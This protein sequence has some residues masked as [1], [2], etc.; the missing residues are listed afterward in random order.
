ML[1]TG[2]GKFGGWETDDFLETGE[3]EIAA[4][5]E[6]AERLG[7]PLQRKRALDFGCGV[8]RAT[9]AL[10]PHFG[11]VL[12]V[13]ISETMIA[14][15]REL[16]ADRAGCTFLL[17]DTPDL[18]RFEDGCFDMVYSRIVLQHQ[19]DDVAIERYLSEFVRL[20]EPSGL[21]VFQLP[22]ALPLMLRIQP[23]RRLFL[24]LSRIGLKTR[25]LYWRLG[26]HPVAMRALPEE[27]VRQLVEAAGGRILEVVSQRDP[28]FGFDDGLYFVTKP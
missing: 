7:R 26:L 16:H 13:D 21:L 1:S 3:R 22:R 25:A 15:A 24:L 20:L 28:D 23:R 17:N 10:A 6:R 5:L 11:E 12:G 2:Q 19:P 27:R 4:V 18:R 14:R 9:R 8:G